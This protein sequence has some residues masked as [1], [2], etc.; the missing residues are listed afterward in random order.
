MDIPERKKAED[1]IR[2]QEMELRQM[3]DL[4]P[5][6]VA[7]YGPERLYAN[8]IMVD[9]LG[10][11]LDEWR[12]KSD[13]SEFFHPEDRERA[14]SDFYRALS[15]SSAYEFELRIRKHDGSYRWFLSRFKPL[16]RRTWID[17]ALV[18]GHHR[19]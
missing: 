6:L 15:R 13:V 10:I 11:S 19:Y 5:Q 3:L 12:Q 4:A 7:V 17:H 16:A 1:K 14:L 8:R 18:C 9:Y 2:E